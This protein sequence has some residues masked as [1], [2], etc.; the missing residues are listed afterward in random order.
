MKVESIFGSRSAKWMAV[1]LVLLV[2]LSPASGTTQSKPFRLE[3][4]TIA[5]IHAAYKSGQLTAH[6]LV[7][8][9]LDRIA[10]Y[11]KKGPKINSIITLNPKALEEA[12]RL[13]AAFKTSGL[14][15]P[16]HGIPVALKDMIDA[17][18]MPT[19]QGSVLFK[20]YYPEKDAFVVEKL[21]KAGAIILA[22]VTM[23]EFATGDTYGS[24]FGETRNPYD[25]ERTVGGS[26]GGSGASTNANFATIAVGQEGYASIRRP[27]A[28]N[29]IVGMRPTA[30]LVSGSGV[31]G[32]MG[33]VGSLG[34]MARTVSDL[35][36]LL[37]VMV[38]YDSA[39]PK[40]ALGV[41]NIPS[42]YTQFLDRS[43]LKGARIGVIREP[44]GLGSEPQSEDFRKVTEVFD[45]AI[46]EM[47]TAG[48]EV[49][50]PI[51]IPNLKKLLATRAGKPGDGEGSNVYFGNNPTA[52][53]KS[54]KEMRESP[55][56]QKV[57]PAA[58][59]RANVA[60]PGADFQTSPTRYYEY[61]L[62][63]QELMISVMKVM[64]DNRLDAIVYKTVEHLPTLIADGIKP[65]YPNMKGAPH[66]NTFLVYVPVITVPAGFSKEKLPVGITFQ[67]RPYTEGT[68]IKLAYAF[69]Q[70]THHRIP[71]LLKASSQ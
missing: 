33:E 37:D 70:A 40:T 59:M 6:Q 26:S 58:R 34:P 39:D 50:D 28:W 10:A 9:Y 57:F 7:Q 44:M 38:G 46:G 19:T 21:E 52:P 32:G 69:E 51:T 29:S 20:N 41:G 55:D 8:L 22:K 23:A 68:L 60:A 4:T 13:D 18:G 42:S 61:L 1:A 27:S 2:L 36:K 49:V 17:K 15:G 5:D 12:D 56:Y 67:G 54:S 65:P 43:G 45:K 3:E 62:A 35:A 66:L 30:G 47:K 31:V 63:R 48:A 71:P 25:L 64:A 11:D 53:F 24:L 16:L 14:V